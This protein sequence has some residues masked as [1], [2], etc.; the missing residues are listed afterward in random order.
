MTRRPLIAAS[1]IEVPEPPELL[2][3]AIALL[4]LV[5]GSGTFL[6]AVRRRLDA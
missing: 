4:L 1:V 3:E 2:P 6:F 5:L